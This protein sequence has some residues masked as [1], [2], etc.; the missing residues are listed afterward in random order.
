MEEEWEAPTPFIEYERISFP[1]EIFPDW[2]CDFVRGLSI[3]AQVPEAMPGLLVIS[4]LAAASAKTYKIEARP[5]WR[6]QMGIYCLTLLETG[7]RKTLTMREVTAPI[8]DFEKKLFEE[9][10]AEY[11][12]RKHEI[13][14][15]K[16]QIEELKKLYVKVKNGSTQM[17]V[18]K[19]TTGKTPSEIKTEIDD[20]I[21]QLATTPEPFL[22]TLI[23]CDVTEEKLI[24]LAAENDGSIANF[25]AEGELFINAAGRYNNNMPSFDSLLKGY[26]GDPIRQDRIGRPPQFVDDPRFTIGIAAQPVVL[27]ALADKPEYKQKG[28]LGR[29]LYAV[30]SSPLG[31]RQINS[32]PITKAVRDRYHNGIRKLLTGNWNTQEQK[33]LTL[34]MA[35]NNLLINFEEELEPKLRPEGELRPIIDWAAKLSGALVRIAGLLHLAEYIDETDKPLVVEDCTMQK[36]L[37][38]SSFLINHA[39]MAYNVIETADTEEIS[40][41][42]RVL[43]WMKENDIQQFS[44]RD[45]QRALQGSIKNIEEIRNALKRLEERGFIREKATTTTGPGRRSKEYNVNPLTIELGKIQIA[46]N[47][48]NIVNFVTKHTNLKSEIEPLFFSE[49]GQAVKGGVC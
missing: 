42:M 27:K 19:K 2:L 9:R 24:K 30:P 1:L 28:L 8:Y 3:Q 32:E 40:N 4:A 13:D 12:L 31:N 7:N 10:R 11:E 14:M 34:S 23:T 17:N 20:L 46:S 38:L 5:G 35:A 6:E 39:K 49:M 37:Y 26:S 48:V 44:Q 22:P 15:L 41:V 45:C 29:F 47:S 21:Q 25:S 18:G 43:R 36:A 33:L 16:A